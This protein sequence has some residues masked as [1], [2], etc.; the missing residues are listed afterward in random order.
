MSWK[1]SLTSIWGASPDDKFRNRRNLAF[2]S[3]IW[4]FILWP[5]ELLFLHIKYDIDIDLIK[6]LLVYIGTLATGTIGGW[7]FAAIKDDKKNDS[8]TVE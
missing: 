8:S 4:S 7:I 6:A 3:A 1:I 5:H 2:F